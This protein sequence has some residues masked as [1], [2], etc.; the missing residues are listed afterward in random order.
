[1]SAEEGKRLGLPAGVVQRYLENFRYYLEPP[2]LDGLE[3]FA[4]RV[5]PTYRRGELRFWDH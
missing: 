3:E 5:D 2:D 1:V 4:A